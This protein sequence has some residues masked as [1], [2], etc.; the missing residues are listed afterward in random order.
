MLDDP[1]RLSTDIDIVVAP[2]TDMDTYIEKAGTI[3][4][5][6]RVHEDH[7]EGA[8]NIEKRHFRFHFTS[9]RIGEEITVLLDAVFEENPYQ[10]VC[11][12]KIKNNESRRCVKW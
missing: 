6:L 3:F 10:K 4:P 9:P 12:R 1:R 5:F 2:G 11:E 7:R 8:N